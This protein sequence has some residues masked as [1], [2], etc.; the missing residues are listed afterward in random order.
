MPSGK[1][2]GPY[3]ALAARFCLSSQTWYNWMLLQR[4]GTDALGWISPL[5]VS[6]NRG[7]DS[8]LL[9]S[10][11]ALANTFFFQFMRSLIQTHNLEIVRA[12]CYCLLH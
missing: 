10:V 3:L 6:E 9:V 11:Y 1:G 2:V 8:N 5:N 4:S 12:M 7:Y